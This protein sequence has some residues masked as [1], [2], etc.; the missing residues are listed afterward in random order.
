MSDS[1]THN[2]VRNLYSGSIRQIIGTLLPFLTRTVLLYTL[3]DRYTGLS[4]LFTSVLQVLNLTDMGFSTVVIYV[5]YK[6]VA[7]KDYPAI[8]AILAYLK[9]I[10]RV[11]GVTMLSIGF[12]LMPFIPILVSEDIPQNENVYIL[13]TLYLVNSAASYFFFA[14]KNALLTVMQ[15]QDIIN[16]I[17]SITMILLD[18]LRITVLL[19]F[20]SFY[21]YVSAAIFTTILNSFL[22]QFFSRKFFPQIE[23]NG[24]IPGNTKKFFFQQVKGMLINRIGDT[25]RN[26]LDNIVLS[27]LLG[28]TTVTIYGNYYYIFSGLYGLV[29]M[30]NEALQASVGNSVVKESTEKNYSDLCNFSYNIAW[31]TGWMAICMACLYQPFMELWMR[32]NMK[33]L[34]SDKIMFLFCIYFYI[35]NMN[36]VR[37]LYIN[38]HGLY[39]ELRAWY[40]VEAVGNVVLNLL[41]GYFFGVSGILWAT[42]L[43]VFF[44][45]FIARTNVLFKFYFRRNPK[46]FYS[47]HLIYAVITLCLGGLSWLLCETVPAKGIWGLMLRACICVVVPNGLLLIATWKTRKTQSLVYYAKKI[48]ERK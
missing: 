42:I 2:T 14:Y 31:L 29:L 26:S 15:R 28:L 4:N 43:T 1:R 5:L 35:I 18:V 17:Q 48:I 32:G 22:I 12:L 13:Y 24:S 36:N 41:L 25:A 11:V 46:E 33:L 34:F 39:W 9:K 3:D 38:A 37:N 21:L 30:I 8:C 19:L 45:N 44:F 7:E 27:A 16:N 40:I 23:A 10:Y 6:P 20:K 47:E